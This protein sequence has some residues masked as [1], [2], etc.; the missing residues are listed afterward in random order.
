MSSHRY[1][2]VDA[3]DF[4]Q[5]EGI[6]RGI[7]KGYEQ[8]IITSA[9][10]MVRRAAAA[11]AARLSLE[12]PGLSVGMHFE[13]CEWAYQN[14]EWTLLYE[15]VSEN[16]ADSVK[17]EFARQLDAFRQLFGRDPSH[18]NSHQHVHRS[19]PVR[20]VMLEA[21]NWMGIPLREVHPSIRYC[22][23][24]YGQSRT[25]YPCHDFISVEWLKRIFSELEPGITELGCHPALELDFEGV[26]ADERLLE[27]SV[28]C[29]PHAPAADGQPQKRPH[30][31]RAQAG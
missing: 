25:G 31:D 29:D 7:I 17:E 15:V 2:I 19:E 5:S 6:N 28:L 23:D 18:L 8:G 4:G 12:H 14:D 9:S 1:L 30:P 13:L 27:L 24:F 11:D 10:L 26:Y 20:C 22:G 16:D 21:A 3:D